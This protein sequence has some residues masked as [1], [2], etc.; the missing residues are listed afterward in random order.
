M[1]IL[2]TGATGFL[3]RRIAVLLKKTIEESDKIVLLTSAKIRGYLCI[4]HKN[5]SYTVEDFLE[6][7]IDH[8]D[9]V[10]HVGW[11]CA[12][13]NND[14]MD[15][16]K[17]FSPVVNTN[18]LLSHLPNIPSKLIFCSSC[19]IYGGTGT[20]DIYKKGKVIDEESQICLVDQYATAKY[21][22]ELFMKN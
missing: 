8:I 19:N 9:I 22:T 16:E 14:I 11:F 17:N 12:K 4:Y 10:I 5:Y 3:G 13:S 1:N 20:F 15:I 18:Y 21:V 2:L 6:V 7:G